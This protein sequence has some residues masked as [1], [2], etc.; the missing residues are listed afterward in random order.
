MGVMR[1]SRAR[2]ANAS[3]YNKIEG[4]AGRDEVS[5]NMNSAGSRA[6]LGVPL[7]ASAARMIAL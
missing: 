4:S 3:N 2:R 1:S 7:P 6:V 5:K